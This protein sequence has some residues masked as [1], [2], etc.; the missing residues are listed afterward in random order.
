[1]N[2]NDKTKE[3]LINELAELRQQVAD[4]EERVNQPLVDIVD[5]D[6]AFK[7]ISESIII[8]DVNGDITY[9][10]PAFEKITG[11][12][13]TEVIGQTP[14]FLKSGQQDGVEMIQQESEAKFRSLVENSPNYIS[15][16]DRE[17]IILFINRV[18]PKTTMEDVVG[19]TIYEHVV[20]KQRNVLKKAVEHVFETGGTTQVEY[21]GPKTGLWY[22]SRFAPIRDKGEVK[23]VIVSTSNITERK[24][25]EKALRESEYRYHELFEQMR[26]GVAVYLPHDDGTDF[27]ITDINKS[28]ERISQVKRKDIIGKSVLKIFTSIKEFG[29]FDVFR[30]V[31]QTGKPQHHPATL[32]KDDH[33]SL[34]AENYVYKLPSGEIVAIYDDVT[35]RKQVKIAL[36]QRATQ[37]SLINEIGGK[38]VSV[39]SL[40]KVLNRAV[41]LVQRGFDYHHVAVFLVEKNQLSLKAVAGS[42]QDYF[43]VGSHTQRLDE[44]INGWVATHGKKVV[45]NDIRTETRYTSLIAEHTITQAELCLPINISGQTVGVFDIQSPQLDTFTEND[46]LVM[47]A[48]SNQL[49]L[50][51]ENARLYESVQQELTERKRAERLL[52]EQEASFQQLFH[53]VNNVVWT[54]A[55]NKMRYMNPATK[56]VY[57]RSITEFMENPNLW[58]KVIHPDDRDEA[59]ARAKTLFV[60]GYVEQIYRI[61]CP[62]GD[63]RWIYDHKSLILDDAG[64]VIQIGGIA[65]DIT[66]LKRTEQA[67]Q[68]TQQD[69]QVLVNVV[70]QAA[71]SIVITD[72]AGIITYVNPF[73]E[74]ITGYPATEA[75]GQD[76]RILNSGYQEKAI[77]EEL[78]TTILGG[79]VW[80]GHFI[81]RRKDGSLYHEDATF[82]PILDDIGQMTSYVAIK[83]DIT[84]KIQ[85]EATVYKLNRA[86][87]MLSECNKTIVRISDEM[88]LLHDTCQH[89]VEIGGYRLAWVGFAEHDT[90]KTVRPVA[91]YGYEEG[92]LDTMKIN[93]ADTER[94][95]GPT[96]TTIRTGKP[97]IIQNILTNPNYAPWQAEAT[98]RKYASSI[99]LPLLANGQTFGVLNIYAVE[100]DAFDDD[101]INL[102]MELVNDLA[103]GV[104]A[105]RIRADR[106]LT[107]KA[108]HESENLHRTTLGS[109]SDAVFITDFYGDF[110]YI[111]TNA[112]VIFGYSF[113]EIR[114]FGNISKL[115]LG[116]IF[117]PNELKALGEIVNIE[118][119]IKDKIGQTHSL[120][121]NVKQ[122]SVKT[123]TILYTCRDV[124]KRKQAEIA[125][126][127]AH[128]ELAQAYNET[129]VGWGR[130]L[131]LRDYETEGHSQ[132]VTELSLRLAR[133]M[134]ITDESELI[135]IQRGALLHD[136]GKMGVPDNI[137]LKSGPLTDAEWEIMRQHPV[138]AY[139]MLKPIAYLHPALDIPY[140]HHEKWDG[141]GYPRG[142]KGEEIP[143]AARIF[144][145][146]DVWDALRSDRPYRAAWSK[147]TV[148]DYIHQRA[149]QQFDPQ[150]VQVF[151]G[152]MDRG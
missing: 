59:K 64:D 98:K 82:F 33:L 48:L 31:W 140:C 38:I 54:S 57:G 150:V 51:I 79:G 34:W 35:A 4:L 49:A 146:V 80:Y 69:L 151:L 47:E 127:Q 109:I 42:Y 26:N 30:Q 142:L 95:R 144:S 143:L 113:E 132:R 90:A 139:D 83:K 62:D 53:N 43:H 9:V 45:A 19:T 55:G 91:Q 3:E 148:L 50:A 134:G 36:Q 133:A 18:Y 126:R 110:T 7:H 28:G 87:R 129:I 124:T 74:K 119:E 149:G 117:I 71:I 106:A 115:L 112:E 128:T 22:E 1:M 52:R 5:R 61:I 21:T 63:I 75:I 72:L 37:L 6:M 56:R 17:G 15:I 68:K 65:T 97:T 25:T 10:N 102:L 27:I 104:V 77:Y 86:L 105:L 40:D 103:Y 24:H 122:V 92:Y 81:N 76:S 29:L 2:D 135:H 20:P 111:C 131:E 99:A 13:A 121:V 11:Y 67:L 41:Q 46:I 14:R 84:D 141:S 123:G 108:L 88:T 16:L 107:V 85:A 120:L 66:N 147:E 60:D 138:Y 73:F 12:S 96:G 100:P 78:W 125:L 70:E 89:I 136:I 130:A 39:L 93:W 145:V 44:G 152:F 118:W 58:F 101:E 137:L 8:T 23:T 94:G 32:Y 116:D 114:A